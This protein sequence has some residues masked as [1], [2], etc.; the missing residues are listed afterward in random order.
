[1]IHSNEMPTNL[2]LMGQVDVL[3]LRSYQ[4]ETKRR[5]TTEVNGLTDKLANFEERVNDL[6]LGLSRTEL[7]A[8]DIRKLQSALSDL[9]NDLKFF[10]ESSKVNA[11]SQQQE[12]E[13]QHVKES[14]ET[15]RQLVLGNIFTSPS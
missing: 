12:E 6:N 5:I 1:M 2:L 9:Q 8:T 13:R 7:N 4:D 3:N 10:I 11:Q 14:V 15:L